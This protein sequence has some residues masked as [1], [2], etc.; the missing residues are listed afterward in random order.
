MDEGFISAHPDTVFIIHRVVV[1][2][3]KKTRVLV[4]Q[5]KLSQLLFFSNVSP[6]SL[7][8]SNPSDTPDT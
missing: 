4:K 7:P 1:Q 6:L 5:L 8:F 2:Y 3:N